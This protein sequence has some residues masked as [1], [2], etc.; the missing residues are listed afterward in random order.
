MS[1]P[2]GPPLNEFPSNRFKIRPLRTDEAIRFSDVPGSGMQGGY[3]QN[4]LARGDE[5]SGVLIDGEPVSVCW[6]ARR[7]P[8]PLY[9]W[10]NVEFFGDYVYVHGVFT[11]P[12]HRG[13][14]MVERNL[15]AAAARY[16][17]AGA[18]GM[19]ALVESSNYASLNAFRKAG[20]AER[21]T[22]RTAKI[23]ARLFI[24]HDSECR[25]ARVFVAP[26]P[27]V[28]AEQSQESITHAA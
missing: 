3:A 16:G 28:R 20:Y 9:K 23:G 24:R 13:K 4:A 15:H 10:W 18:T 27:D 22:I 17:A 19:F 2:W 11:L 8:V 5:C 25:L 21:A 7:G 14:R 1:L 6:Y 26:R 12:A